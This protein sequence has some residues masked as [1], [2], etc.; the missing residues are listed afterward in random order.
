MKPL[1]MTVFLCQSPEDREDPPLPEDPE[2]GREECPAEGA[3]LRAESGAQ[4]QLFT[5]AQLELEESVDRGT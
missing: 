5:W 3:L 1:G 2:V 4:M